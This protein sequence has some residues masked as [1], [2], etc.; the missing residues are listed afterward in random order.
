MLFG[1]VFSTL[2]DESAVGGGDGVFSPYV[3]RLGAETTGRS[4]SIFWLLLSFS[5]I[6][7]PSGGQI[8]RSLKESRIIRG[9]KA[10]ARTVVMHR[11][12]SA[13][14]TGSP[15]RNIRLVSSLW[16]CYIDVLTCEECQIII[17]LPEVLLIAQK[18]F[19]IKRLT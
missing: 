11:R 3:R 13:F 9:L 15:A 1:G 17:L 7:V 19:S 6:V 2:D 10:F 8:P 16:I 14:P 5:M 4:R 12:K 18:G